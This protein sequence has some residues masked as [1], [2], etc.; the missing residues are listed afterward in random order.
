MSDNRIEPTETL[1]AADPS[2]MQETN[3]I[4]V[5]ICTYKRPL[6]L[7]RLLTDLNRQQTAGLFTYSIVVVDNDEAQSA[8][9]AIADF[10][11]ASIVPVKYCVEPTRGIAL[12]RNKVVQNAEG[13]FL[14]FIDDDEF[15]I[16]QWLLTLFKTCRDYKVDG[17]LGP[18]RRYFDETPPAWILKSHLYDRKINPTG[19]PVDWHE[20]RTGNVLLKKQIICE[21]ATPFRPEL[22]T[23][24]DRDFFKRKIEEG[25]HFVWSAEA[26]VFE[27]LPPARWKRMFYVKKALLQGAT[28]AQQKR[29]GVADIAKSIVALLLYTIALPF[30]LLLGQHRFMT[31]L[32]KLCGHLGKLLAFMGFQFIKDAYVSD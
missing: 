14:A 13:P 28:A 6:P 12:A 24:E 25:H 5:C 29:C 10:R 1:Q 3:H 27:V 21:D 4:S 32:V 16:A 19:M 26:E 9:D 2:Q 15:P 8:K 20:A 31:L 7:K 18:V 11:P 23:G 30:T 17:V 22:R